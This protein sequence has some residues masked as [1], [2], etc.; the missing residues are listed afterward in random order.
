M[1]II[2]KKRIIRR[3]YPNIHIMSGYFKK[4]ASIL[5]SQDTQMVGNDRWPATICNAAGL[6]MVIELWRDVSP[7][8]RHY[9]IKGVFSINKEKN[10]LIFKEGMYCFACICWINLLLI[11]Q[12]TSAVTHITRKTSWDTYKNMFSLHF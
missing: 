3:S 10:Y 12:S 2:F 6:R 5:T 4:S 1:I 8:F 9:L 7:I 11:Y